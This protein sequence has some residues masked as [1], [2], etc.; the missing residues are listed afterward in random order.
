MSDSIAD[1]SFVATWLGKLILFST[2]QPGENRCPGL[3]VAEFGFLNLHDKEDTWSPNAIGGMNLTETKVLAAKF[4]AC[5]AFVDSERF[6]PALFASADTNSRLSEI[7]NDILKRS[8]PSISL[9]DHELLE[10]LFQIYLGTQGT[11]GSLPARVPLQIKILGLLSKS[12]LSSSFI[13]QS[14]RIIQDGLIPIKSNSVNE[15][16]VPSKLGL[17]TSK[18]RVRVFAFT[19]WLAKVSPPSSISAFAPTLVSQ[20]RA[21]VESQGWPQFHPENARPN[22]LEVNARVH[23]Y[24][25]I[26]LLAAAC[27][28]LLLLEPNLDLLGWLFTSLTA[29]PSGNN[30]SLGIEQALGSILGAFGQDLDPQLEDSLTKLLLFYMNLRPTGDYGFDHRV[31]RSPRSMALRFTNRCLPYKNVTARWINVLALRDEVNGRSEIVEEGKKGLHPYW[32]KMWNPL[33]ESPG[34]RNNL[35]ISQRYQLPDYQELIRKFFGPGAEWDIQKLEGTQFK[36]SKAYGSALGFCRFILLSHAL[37]PTPKAPKINADWERNIDALVVSD[38]ESRTHI[39]GFLEQELLAKKSFPQT[40]SFSAPKKNAL[41]IYLA[42]SFN[43]LVNHTGGESNEPGECLLELCSLGCDQLLD[44][45][46]NKISN[47]AG[48]ILSNYKSFRETAAH[49]FGILASRQQSSK[50]TVQAM[51]QIFD[52]KIQNWAQAVG[53]EIIQ[54]HGAILAKAYFVSRASYRGNIS[55]DLDELR[56]ELIKSLIDILSNCRDKMLLEAA[57]I[58][59]SELGLFAAIS[60]DTIPKPLTLTSLI[61]NLRQKAN[62]GGEKAIVA[63]GSLAM[64]CDENEGEGATLNQIIDILYSLH[65]VR[66]PEVQFAVGASLTCAAA[67]WHSK[68]LMAALD[69]QGAPPQTCH[70][71]T[72]LPRVIKKVLLDCSKTKPALRQAAVI[73]LLCLVQYCGHSDDVKSRFRECQSAF[74]GFLADRDSLNQE[75]ASRGLTLIYEK[76]DKLL[77]EDLVRDLIASFTGSG[78]S[79]AGK[80]SEETE[81]F[82]PGALPTGEGSVTTYKDIMNLASEV[83]NPGLVY[84]FMSLASNNAIWSS[85][86]AFG[87]FGLSNILS[88]SS[89]DGYLA[90]NPKL[91]STLFRYRFDPNPNVR[92][93][94]NEIWSVLAKEPAMVINLYFN[95]IIEDLLENI[96]GREWRVRQASC[97]AIADL[98]QGRPVEKYQGYLSEIW[99]KTFKVTGSRF[100]PGTIC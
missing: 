93:S 18:L 87:R 23:G 100:Q 25:S 17:E 5:G 15:D 4:L 33:K 28:D 64:Q 1:A 32:Y 60:H 88:D 35:K 77:K 62:S 83:G 40:F 84:Q 52:Q 81:L 14:I 11:D 57:M 86:A 73:W 69:I 6:L 70:R 68:A 72:T 22:V 71:K 74:K 51:L 3:D 7:G 89:M 49:V 75:S 92:T 12:R 2:N 54:T 29:D 94:M 37:S 58:A 96:L 99:T 39:K 97:A 85:R 34:I 44:G 50:A 76:G 20:L 63:L 36:I 59:V 8:T 13:E 61:E 65:E 27:P 38:E 55:I 43:G 9:E 53:S 79:L 66:Q 82:E 30:V 56:P 80:I 31:V 19:N 95:N 46:T 10:H 47:L 42:T 48:P 16:I 91:Y 67:G 41:E 26:G 21:Y 98:L 24:E 45:L 78:T 90:Q